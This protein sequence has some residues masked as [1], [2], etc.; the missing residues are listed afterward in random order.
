[1]VLPQ[2]S[3]LHTTV[4]QTGMALQKHVT[5]MLV[6]APAPKPLLMIYIVVAP[7]ETLLSDILNVNWT[8]AFVA[9]SP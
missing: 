9:V 2:S 4:K 7:T 8:S 5:L 6:V 3:S 1:M